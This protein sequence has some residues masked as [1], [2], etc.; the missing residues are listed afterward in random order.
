MRQRIQSQ[1]E[2]PGSIPIAVFHSGPQRKT[3]APKGARVCRRMGE[4]LG[5]GGHSTRR[6]AFN[7]RASPR[8]LSSKLFSSLASP[9]KAPA[10]RARPVCQIGGQFD[11][12][13]IGKLKISQTD[14]KASL[15]PAAA[16]DHVA[17]ADR[18]PAGEIIWERGHV[19]PPRKQ[20]PSGNLAAPM[21]NQ[22]DS[23][24]TGPRFALIFCESLWIRRPRSPSV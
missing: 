13:A 23:S 19:N 9:R 6:Y 10:T 20:Q 21:P 14:A 12:A 15:S 1:A 2:G 17:R 11:V 22:G 18:E 24:A 4:G 16:L 5:A 7:A 8:F 3:P